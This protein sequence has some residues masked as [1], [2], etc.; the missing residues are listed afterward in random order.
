[1]YCPGVVMLYACIYDTIH[2]EH[3][4]FTIC[5]FIYYYR[6]KGVVGP[7]VDRRRSI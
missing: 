2:T 3:V 1:M 6:I 4:R 5:L 7:Y